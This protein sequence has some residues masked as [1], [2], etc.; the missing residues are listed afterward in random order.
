MAKLRVHNFSVSLDEQCVEFVP[1]AS[2]AHV[3]LAKIH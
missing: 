2:V 1:T 3:R